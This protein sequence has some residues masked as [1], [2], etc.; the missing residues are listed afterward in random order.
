MKA[1]I[2]NINGYR[3]R[4]AL[5]IRMENRSDD[6]PTKA[7][8]KKKNASMI[9]W[10]RQSRGKKQTLSLYRNTGALLAAGFC[11]VV[12]RNIDRPGLMSTLPTI[13]G[14]GFDMHWISVPI[15]KH[16]PSSAPIPCLGSFYAKMFVGFRNHV[17]VCSTM[18][19]AAKG[20]IARGET[21]ELLVADES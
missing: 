20:E 12:S 8:R 18:E 10:L 15:R 14:K 3:A 6:E 19:Q 4:P 11:V 17:L 5:S 13:D 16:S 21:Y 7:I 1:K 2:S 9:L